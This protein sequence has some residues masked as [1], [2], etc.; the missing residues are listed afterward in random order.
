MIIFQKSKHTDAST[1]MTHFSLHF[2]S[3]FLDPF[4]SSTKTN[5]RYYVVTMTVTMPPSNVFPMAPKAK[6]SAGTK[7]QPTSAPKPS[8]KVTQSAPI[9]SSDEED[10][11]LPPQPAK[12]HRMMRISWTTARTERL[13]DWLKENPV[14]LLFSDSTKDTKD[15]G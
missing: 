10:A 5:I 13:L 7:P 4:S 1:K 3:P 11:E 14:D 12:A 9:D 2:T 8:S 6:K 15:E